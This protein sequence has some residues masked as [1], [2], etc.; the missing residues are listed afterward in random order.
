MARGPKGGEH[1]VPCLAP[2]GAVVLEELARRVVAAL[3]VDAREL[4]GIPAGSGFIQ[5]GL[6]QD[7]G[8]P[9]LEGG[10]PLLLAG[11]PVELPEAEA[12]EKR[13]Q[14]RRRR[15]RQKGRRE[16]VAGRLQGR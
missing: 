4:G 10:L 15:G 16:P 8:A 6:V 1:V 2:V 13:E 3:E 12:A 5:D 11:R 14:H 9:R 7:D